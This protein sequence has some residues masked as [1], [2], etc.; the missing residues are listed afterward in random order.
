MQNL[1]AAKNAEAWDMKKKHLPIYVSIYMRMYS[2]ILLVVC[3]FTGHIS[4]IFGIPANHKH[5]F[6]ELVNPPEP[7]LPLGRISVLFN[8]ITVIPL[9]QQGRNLH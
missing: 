5:R 4:G 1:Y 3:L 9:D 8:R 6:V 7:K 2:F